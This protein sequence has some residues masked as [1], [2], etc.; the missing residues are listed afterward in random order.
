MPVRSVT[1]TRVRARD[2]WT[3]APDRAPRRAD[4]VADLLSARGSDA[5]SQVNRLLSGGLSAAEGGRQVVVGSLSGGTGAST[6]AALLWQAWAARGIP[7][8]MLD[9][10]GGWR[11][12]MA[13]RI[14]PAQLVAR[15]QWSDFLGRDDQQLAKEFDAVRAVAGARSVLVAR[16]GWLPGEVLPPLGPSSGEVRA[17]ACAASRSWPLVV[18]DLGHGAD[19][20]ADELVTQL[21]PGDDPGADAAGRQLWI[22]ELLV[23]VCR[24]SAVELRDAGELLRRAARTH[25]DPRQRVVIAACGPAPDWTPAVASAVAA[26]ADTVAG[27]VRMDHSRSLRDRTTHVHRRHLDGGVTRLAAAVAATPLQRRGTR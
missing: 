15:P 4:G 22:P 11:P 21:G 3:P 18:K 6:V 23:V 10:A 7:G 13:D 1:G 27:V 12:G 5:K 8:V 9:A 24:F 14:N 2:G 20:H 25:I 17:V 26:V 19:S 16:G